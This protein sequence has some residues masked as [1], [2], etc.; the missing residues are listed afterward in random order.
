MRISMLTV[1]LAGSALAALVIS[2]SPALAQCDTFCEVG[3]AGTGGESSDGRAQGFHY[4]V[5]GHNPGSI[6]TNSGNLMAGRLVIARSGDIVGTLTGNYID[7]VC[8][9]SETGIFGDTTGADPDCDEE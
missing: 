8:H 3:A 9:G 4:I 2:S 5:P 1:A 6:A 7:G